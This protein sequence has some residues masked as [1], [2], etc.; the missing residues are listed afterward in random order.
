VPTT[1]L[2][3]TDSYLTAFDAVVTDQG[4]GGRRIYLDRTAFYPT[5]GG[6]PFDTGTLNGIRVTDVVD[7]EDRIAHWLAEPLGATE[8][9]GRID[10]TRRHDYMQQHTGQH[11]LSAVI[12]ER[13]GYETVSVHFGDE[14]STL[15]LAV[16]GITPEALRQMESWA[17]VVVME[18]R[19]VTTGSE[20]AAT[21]TGLRKIP[22]RS[23]LLR[24]MTIEQLDRSACGGT[25]VRATGEIGPVLIRKAERMKQQVRLEFLCG[26]RA[27]RRTRADFELLSRMA[28]EASAGIDDLPAAIMKLRTELKASQAE[29]R[30]LEEQLHVHRARALHHATTPDANGWRH[31]VID[32]GVSGVEDLRGLAMAAIALPATIVTG[33]LIEPPTLLLATSADTGLDAGTLLKPVLAA[34]GGRGGGSA[35]IAQGSLPAGVPAELAYAEVAG[36]IATLTDARRR[37]GPA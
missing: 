24:I 25:H 5:S 1:R 27:V 15:D 11:L 2:Y 22:E 34:L 36:A 16:A 3:Y 37:A 28:G 31:L 29:R 7:E 8:V 14:S 10:W 9:K 4:D 17:S 35:R 6:Q 33:I 18:N 12:A 23:G 32:T 19:A 21:A 30:A 26:A 20:D 13:L